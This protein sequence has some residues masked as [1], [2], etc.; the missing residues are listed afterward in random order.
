MASKKHRS[1]IRP[2]VFLVGAL[3]NQC[4]VP[5]SVVL[6]WPYWTETT[7]SWLSS[8]CSPQ[9]RHFVR[10]ATSKHSYGTDA[11]VNS[12]SQDHVALDDEGSRGDGFGSPNTDGKL[13]G[14][15]RG[16]GR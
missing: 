3:T 7:R 12:P 6:S 16:G 2:Q 5:E 11:F 10:S 15:A 14:T 1:C 9:P 13:G 8:R 4:G